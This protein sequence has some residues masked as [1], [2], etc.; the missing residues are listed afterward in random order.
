M[1]VLDSYAWVEYFIG[2]DSGRVVK[3][4]LDGEEAFTPSIVLAEVARK[5]LREGVGE[6][7]VLPRLMFTTYLYER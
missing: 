3:E 2:S 4:C 1:I 5:Y 7:Y 6:E